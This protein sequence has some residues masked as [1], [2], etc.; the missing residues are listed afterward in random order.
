[1]YSVPA[2]VVLKPGREGSTMLV[3]E[4]NE[5]TCQT[6]VTYKMW[7]W[8]HKEVVQITERLHVMRRAKHHMHSYPFLQI[9]RSLRHV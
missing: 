5:S 6:I 1:M 8:P 7:K 3:T 4:L 9:L 2:R